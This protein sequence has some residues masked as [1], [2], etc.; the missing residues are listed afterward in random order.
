MQIRYD[1]PDMPLG[2]P[3]SFGGILVLN[4]EVKDVSKK[5][6]D[7]FQR[8]TGKTLVETERTNLQLRIITPR[9]KVS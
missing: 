8:R 3:L 9:K 6:Q 5:D 4:G 2:T 1:W 7:T